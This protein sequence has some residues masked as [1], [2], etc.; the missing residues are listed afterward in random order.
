MRKGIIGVIILTI[1]GFALIMLLEAGIA[2]WLWDIIM[3][4]IF[5]LPALTY[6]EMYGLIWLINILFGGI[7][8]KINEEI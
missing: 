6:W 3:V 2:I 5:N 1:V 8:T 4:D 7:H